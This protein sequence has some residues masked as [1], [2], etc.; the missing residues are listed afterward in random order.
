MNINQ[1][2]ERF[3]LL[4]GI[5]DDE[6]SKW[7]PL[8]YDAQE[9]INSLIKEDTDVQRF[10]EMLS[11][12]VGTYSYYKWCL[13]NSGN[14]SSTFKAGDLTITEGSTSSSVEKALRLWDECKKEIAPYLKSDNFY[15]KGVRI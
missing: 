2:C 6:I 13:V 15:F 7:L 14:T 12:A 4:T 8:I 3:I 10:S 9:Y 1:I 5:S 11:S